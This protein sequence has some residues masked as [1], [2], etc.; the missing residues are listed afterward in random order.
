[1]YVSTV[2]TCCAGQHGAWLTAHLGRNEAYLNRTAEVMNE[3]L[4][5]GFLLGM[6]PSCL[7]AFM[8]PFASWRLRRAIFKISRMI[9][10]LY[11]ARLK[12]LHGPPDDSEPGDYFQILLRF[13]KEH[14][15]D[16]LNLHD[17]TNR[18][19]LANFEAMHQTSVALTNMLL[20]IL[21]SD[22]EHNTVDELRK[23]AAVQLEIPSSDDKSQWTKVQISKLKKADSIARETMRMHSFMSRGL[24]RKVMANDVHTNGG[25]HLPK[26]SILVWP[27]QTA[28]SDPG[29]FDNPGTFDPWR[30][31]RLR[32][33]AQ[34]E[35]ESQINTFVSTAQLLYFGRGRHACPG[36]WLVDFEVKMVISYVTLN[37]DIKFPDEYGGERPKNRWFAEAYMLPKE[38][39]MMVRRRALS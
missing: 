34:T 32:N 9:K 13:A 6:T 21:A 2:T 29:I 14:R 12:T 28:H 19:C 15:P 20:N 18:L 17:I 33:L 8:N 11:E 24:F 26:D 10:P 7:Q 39:S 30:F 1:M 27:M 22:A 25:A 16:E 38:A 5:T 36:R 37:F 3:F 31:E 23:E 35:H 4:I